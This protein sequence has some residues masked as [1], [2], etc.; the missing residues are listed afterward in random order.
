MPEGPANPA[1]RSAATAIAIV[2]AAWFCY[3][4]AKHE[5]ASHLLASANP[6]NWERA[7]RIEPDNP[8]TWYRLGRFR[9]LDFDH[10]DFPLAISYY[11][12]AVQLNPPSPYYKLDLASTLEMSGQNEEAERYFRAA[13]KGY[14]ISA[15]V[16]WKYGNF[17]LRQKRLPEAY[18]EIHR[19]V[20]VDSKLIPLAIS[21][22]WHSDPDVRVLLDQVLPDTSQADSEALTFLSNVQE[23]AAA[24]AVWNR[25]IAKNAHPEWK[26]V[27]ALTELLVAQERFEE[28]GT[29]WRQA[30]AKDEN[31]A[32]G[33]GDNS[34][35]FD[36]GFEQDI[37]RGGFGWQQRDVPGADFDFD[38]DVKHSGNRAARLIFDGSQNL[39]YEDLYQYVLVSP[40]THYRFRGYLRTDQISTDSGVRFEVSDPKDPRHSTKLTPNETGNEP[41]T[42]EETDFTAGPKTHRVLVRLVRRPSQRL[43]NKISGTVWVDDVSLIPVGNQK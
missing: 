32:H 26:T 14:P 17:L 40:G 15:E 12:R 38:S 6:E 28:A 8:D 9:Q 13:Q 21:R 10:A 39:S 2:A 37:L 22:A 4:G 18:A 43:D 27:F 41:W 23:P 5:L 11:Q 24:L 36:G 30:V 7:A 29:V 20:M 16:S 19:A 34:V 25:L 31:A 3:A 1:R 42:L 35:I 33:Y